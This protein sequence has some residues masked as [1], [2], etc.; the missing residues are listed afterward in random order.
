MC[1]DI[2]YLNERLEVLTTVLLNSSILWDITP[3][4][5]VPI[6]INQHNIIPHKTQTI[7]LESCAWVAA[8]TLIRTV[9]QPT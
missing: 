1:T 2:S 7:F 8:A 4:R 3:C 6:H 5:L 9:W